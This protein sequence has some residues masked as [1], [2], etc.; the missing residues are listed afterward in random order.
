VKPFAVS[1]SSYLLIVLGL[2]LSLTVFVF[3]RDAR[4][5]REFARLTELARNERQE[6]DK[7]SARAKRY[8]D[9][10]RGVA[11]SIARLAAGAGANPERHR[12][13]S[14]KLLEGHKRFVANSKRFLAEVEEEKN[15][16]LA[17][18]ARHRTMEQQWR[19]AAR[20]CLE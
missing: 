20:H 7:W 4:I 1:I 2:S 12:V 17:I 13:Q 3:W 19:I 14:P 18:S 11:A 8:D 5:A 16:S 9:I 6:A 15:N 10:Q